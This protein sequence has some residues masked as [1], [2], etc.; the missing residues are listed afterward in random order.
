MFFL[1]D[2]RAVARNGQLKGDPERNQKLVDLPINAWDFTQIMEENWEEINALAIQD[3]RR[4]EMYHG[5]VMG[6]SY[7]ESGDR[8]E[9]KQ[10]LMQNELVYFDDQESETDLVWGMG[11]NRTLRRITVAFRGSVT[12]KDFQQ[13][14]KVSSHSQLSNL[15]YPFAVSF[16]SQARSS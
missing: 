11:V 7:L 10:F 13:D 12:K 6:K 5:S 1:P 16:S 2:F 15:Q 4:A 14:A 9:Q 3:E 8:E